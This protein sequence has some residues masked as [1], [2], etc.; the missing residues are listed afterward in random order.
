MQIFSSCHSSKTFLVELAI[1]N[2][3]MG[4]WW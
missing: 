4:G 3:G 1:P 2:Q